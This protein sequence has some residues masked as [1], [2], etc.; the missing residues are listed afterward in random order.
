M[1]KN[2]D[3]K[4][5]FLNGRQLEQNDILV[6]FGQR[7]Q[8]DIMS[9]PLHEPLEKGVQDVS[10]IAHELDVLSGRVHTL[11]VHDGPLEHV[12]ELGLGAQVRRPHKVN[13]A[14]VLD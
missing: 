3:K 5:T 13:H 14:P 11:A 4:V 12:G 9:A 10:T 1:I 6:L 8:K 7:G 2:W